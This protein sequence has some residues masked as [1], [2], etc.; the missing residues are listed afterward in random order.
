[1]RKSE[2]NYAKSSAGPRCPCG[3]AQRRAKAHRGGRRPGHP[4]M[5]P[6]GL[7]CRP[8]T[9]ASLRF[10]NWFAAVIDSWNNRGMARWNN[11]GL[12]RSD[13]GCTYAGCTDAGC[14]DAGCTDAGCTDAG[15][16]YS[17]KANWK[18]YD[19]LSR[20]PRM[21]ILN[22]SPLRRRSSGKDPA[23]RCGKRAIMRGPT[24]PFS[25]TLGEGATS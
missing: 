7:R 25:G 18:W 8:P 23:A 1:M 11:R 3:L 17:A 9:V 24:G 13:A 14:T 5:G 15:C 16:R 2:S 4:Q 20:T 19:L 22:R 21:G 12:A 6:R 10:Q